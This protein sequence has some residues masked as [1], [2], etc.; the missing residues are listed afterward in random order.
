MP[1]ITCSGNRKGKI[2]HQLCDKDYNSTKKLFFY[3]VKLHGI[4]L[5]RK[6]GL[7]VMEVLQISRIATLS[8]PSSLARVSNKAITKR[9]GVIRHY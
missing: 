9:S 3:G 8:E 4:G 5:H 1:I 2:A 7:P 6:G